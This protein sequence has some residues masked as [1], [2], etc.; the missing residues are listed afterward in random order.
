VTP[1]TAARRYA[2]AL[3]DVVLKQQGNFDRT[4]QELD[5]FAALLTG[6]AGLAAVISNPAVPAAKKRAMV[7]AILSQAGTVSDP[8]ARTLQLLADRDRLSLVP[9][10]AR[11][12]GERVME[13]RQIVRA[14][15]TTAVPLEADRAKALADALGAATGRQV[16]VEPKVDQTILG[17]VVARVGSVIYDGSVARQLEKMKESLVEGGE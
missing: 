3:F 15:V 17:G 7:D 13:H 1:A 16:L 12:F 8:V 2:R 9:Q 6:N 4:R 14:E 10:L 5:D 11:T